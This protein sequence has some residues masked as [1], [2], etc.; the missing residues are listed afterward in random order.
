M[1]LRELFELFSGCP[2]LVI[3]PTRN[4]MV[5]VGFIL[6]H[7]VTDCGF[8]RRNSIMYDICTVFQLGSYASTRVLDCSYKTFVLSYSSSHA[9]CTS[10]MYYMNLYAVFFNK[11]EQT[12]WAELRRTV[13]PVSPP[14]MYFLLRGVFRVKT[15]TQPHALPD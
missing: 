12:V 8:A 7:S 11:H 4:E 6:L 5:T 1:I 9:V 2:I 15:T 3:V 10:S 14:E 13:R